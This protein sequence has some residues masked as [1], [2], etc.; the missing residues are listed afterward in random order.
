[1]KT[2]HTYLIVGLVAILIRLIISYKTSIIPGI[3][4]GYYPV[5][6]REIV[7]NGHLAISDMPLLFYLNDFFVYEAVQP[8][9]LTPLTTGLIVEKMDI[10]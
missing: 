10:M 9:K 1:M 5:Q 8:V 6:I 7:N 3:N 4:G 2:K